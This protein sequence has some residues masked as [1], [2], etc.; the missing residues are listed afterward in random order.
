MKPKIYVKEDEASLVNY[1]GRFVY[2]V[3]VYINF[4]GILSLHN[5]KLFCSDNPIQN[6]ARFI[7]IHPFIEVESCLYSAPEK[8]LI[9]NG[10]TLYVKPEKK[11]RIKNKE[12]D[13][14][15]MPN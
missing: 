9:E 12:N 11:K 10:F 1:S 4:E 2:E 15:S 6:I 14:E 8:W 7:K 3:L 13:E 5:H